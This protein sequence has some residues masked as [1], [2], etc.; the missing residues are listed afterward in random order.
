MHIFFCFN[1]ISYV[2]AKEFQSQSSGITLIIASPERVRYNKKKDKNVFFYKKY[3]GR[4]ILII[5]KF[6]KYVEINIPHDQGDKFIK[7]IAQEAKNISLIDDGLDSFRNIPKNI[8]QSLLNRAKKF[9]TY[10]HGLP[11]ANWVDNFTIIKVCP[12]IKL[13]DDVKPAAIL[14]KY[15]A[16]IFESPGI[17]LAKI[18]GLE[19]MCFFSHPN[20][21]KKISEIP[22]IKKIEGIQYSAEKTLVSFSGDIYI[23]ESMLLIFALCNNLDPSRIHLQ[24]SKEQFINL[25]CLHDLLTKSNV[26]VDIT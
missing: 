9:Y 13:L 16:I 8:S 5:S 3:I 17:N 22:S 18:L 19:E 26:S 12:I 15:K 25:V 7:K 24:I 1:Q 20:I 11:L 21:N 10:D 6:T 2:I 14:D 23:G 4:L